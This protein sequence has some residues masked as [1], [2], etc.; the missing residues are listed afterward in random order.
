MIDFNEKS[1]DIKLSKESNKIKMIWTG[2]ASLKKT[3]ESLDP[4][5]HNLVDELKGNEL[6]VELASLSFINSASILSVVLFMKHLD[7]NDIKTLITYNNSDWQ[8]ASFE[9]VKRLTKMLDNIVLQP[10]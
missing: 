6:T 4:Y 1:L 7:E 5:L 8:K 3:S 10:I 9:A 2:E